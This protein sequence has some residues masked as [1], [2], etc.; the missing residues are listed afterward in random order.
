MSGLPS[1]RQRLSRLLLAVGLAWALAVSA[2]VWLAVR[3]GVD[4]VLDGALQ[5]SAEILYGLLSFH[6]SRLP[7]DEGPGAPAGGGGALPAPPHAEHLVWQIVGPDGALL[8]RSHKAPAQALLPHPGPG[9]ANAAGGWRV[10]A[11]PFGPLGRMLLVAQSARERHGARLD[12]AWLT[13]LATLLVGAPCALLVARG[14][15]RELRPLQA[16]SREVADYEPLAA[17]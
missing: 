12:A 6:A 17:G 14:V 13:V 2:A 11:L 10:Y 5:E 15:R 3:H 16:L 1:I 8:L 9:L 7:L 4:T